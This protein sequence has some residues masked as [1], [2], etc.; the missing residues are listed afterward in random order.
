MS[1]PAKK[2]AARLGSEGGDKRTNQRH[3]STTPGA[4]G[5][6]LTDAEAEQQT[7]GIVLDAPF[8]DDAQQAI[9]KAT[10]SLDADCFS[11]PLGQAA[12]RAIVARTSAGLPVNL[13]EVVGDMEK[14]GQDGKAAVEY[15]T[16]CQLQASTISYLPHYLDRVRQAAHRRSLH[17]AARIAQE[18]LDR[19][20][21]LDDVAA[22]LMAAGEASGSSH[23]GPLVDT[24]PPIRYAHLHALEVKPEET[25]IVGRGFLRRGAWSLFTGGTGIG[26][27]VLA[28]QMA[29][30]VACGKS[31]FGLTVARPFNVLALTAEQDEETLKRDLEAIAE[32]EG[33]DPDLL[34]ANLQLHHA[35][36]LDGPELVTALDGEFRRGGF[37]L[38]VVDNYQ[39][40][41]AD[42]ING[43]REW[44]LFITPIARLLKEYGAAMLLVDHT[45]KPAERKGWGRH[46]SVYIAAG[47][48]RKANGART[49]LELYSPAE[50]DDRY[51]LHL[52]KNWE[53]AGVV[54]GNGFPIRDIYLDRAPDAHKPYWTPSD[55]QT[56]HKPMVEGERSIVDYA[57]AH[58]FA[59]V[60]KV[61]EATGHSKSKVQR[62]LAKHPLLSHDREE[63]A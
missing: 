33:L 20:D 41:S 7:V 48:S 16:A 61:A 15:L 17:L 60:R 50:G 31:V 27:S 1:T 35:Y 24:F 54:D 45:G 63:K 10:A 37:D 18:A 6:S 62:I 59:G 21:A 26:K 43:S 53:R 34:D 3:E 30:C 9:R 44:K 2:E 14:A 32:H 19:G 57:T 4:P 25:H 42:D 23:G 29:A 13:A 58:P 56:D 11:D 49:S 5:A 40:F 47:T 12:W 55:D 28:E 8:N 52:G 39:A 38:L 36:A 51:R 46:D 22:D